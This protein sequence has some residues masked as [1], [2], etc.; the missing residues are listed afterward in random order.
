MQEP[1]TGKLNPDPM[2]KR[3]IKI[4]NLLYSVSSRNV[5][6]MDGLGSFITDT[7]CGSQIADCTM[8]LINYEPRTHNRRSAFMH[9]ILFEADLTWGLYRGEKT[10]TSRGTVMTVPA[11]KNGR[12]SRVIAE[13]DPNFRN[14]TVYTRRTEEHYFFYPFLEVLTIN[15]LADG[16]GALLHSCCINDNGSGYLFLGQSGAGKSTM[17][18]LWNEEKGITVLSDDRVLV[19]ITE[20]GLTAYGTP[21]HGTEKYAVNASVPVKKI[22]FISHAEKNSVLKLSGIKAASELV[23]NAFLPFWD[24]HRMEYSTEFLI[25]V[26]QKARLFSLG[27]YPD[28]SIIDLVRNI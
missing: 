2:L 27:V 3:N 6:D 24:K 18:N 17:A 1:A 16:K 8:E 5:M 4:G 20:Q 9:N 23:K 11:L 10:D 12:H 28:R 7:D 19:S 21:W 13:F 25:Q 22:F 15:L 26:S 14:G